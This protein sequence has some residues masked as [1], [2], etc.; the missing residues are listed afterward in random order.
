MN[1]RITSL[2]QSLGLHCGKV[3]CASVVWLLLG[4]DPLAHGQGQTGCAT[5]ASPTPVLATDCNIGSRQIDGVS[6]GQGCCGPEA[7]WKQWGPIPWEAFAHGEYVGVARSSHVNEY[8]LRV[9]DQLEFIYRLTREESKHP[10]QLNVGD[11][12]RIELLS[13]KEVD[14]QLVIQPDGTITVPL[15]G[16]V[17]AARRTVRELQEVLEEQYTKYYKIPNVTVTPLKVNARL[18]DLR[19]TVDARQGFGGGQSRRAIVTPEGTVQ[20]VA[21][22]SIPAQ[23]LTLDELKREID[24]RYDQ[25]VDGIEVTPMLVERAPRFVYVAG[26]VVTPGRY[27]LE[28]PTTVIQALSLAGGWK[29]GG[30]LR[31]VIVFRR[32]ENW[33]LMATRLDLRG[34]LLGKRPCP[35][36]EIWLRDSDTVLVPS[37]PIRRADDLIEL[38]FTRGIYGVAPFA[39]NG[40][41]RV[42]VLR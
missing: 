32:D 4:G 24:A 5:C 39:A 18:E 12:I 20:L 15:L 23:G 21:I 42:G 19:A 37:N 25:L 9:R 11:E 16:Q 28:A 13:E 6:C 27:T 17:R 31:Q 7:T 2:L 3:T 26:D 41:T 40:V 22:G 30:N 36:D 35:A 1:A 10:Y 8:R 34:A 38:V 33:Q 14:R 29:N